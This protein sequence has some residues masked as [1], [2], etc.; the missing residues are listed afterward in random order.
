MVIIGVVCGEAAQASDV[1]RLT[2]ELE[3]TIDRYWEQHPD[4]TTRQILMALE[5]VTDTVS[6]MEE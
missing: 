3:Q 1:L 2:N 6:T 4:L 5:N